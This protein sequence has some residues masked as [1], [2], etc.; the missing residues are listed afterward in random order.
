[1]LVCDVDA[2]T[3][4]SCESAAVHRTVELLQR[5]E[6]DVRLPNSKWTAHDAAAHLVSMIGRYL[7]A[8]RKRADSARDVDVINSEEIAEFGSATMGE[9]V[10]RLRSR[11]AKYNAFWPELPLDALFPLR[12][13]LPLDVACLR[14]NWISELLIHGRDV[15]LAAGEPWSLDAESSLLTVRLLAHVLHTYV[16]AEDQDDYCLAVAPVGGSPF[17]LVVKDHVAT[18]EAGVAAEAD[19]VS[20]PPAALA[21]LFYGRVGLAEA[22]DLGAFVTGDADRVG[23]FIDRL[24]KP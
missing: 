10:G 6:P 16:R 23:R 7:D 5:V 19:Q 1:M 13:G 14:T 9:L 3:L 24:E 17:T 8:N 12:G 22:A 11:N 4:A 2:E 18:I 20:G 15:A 21:L